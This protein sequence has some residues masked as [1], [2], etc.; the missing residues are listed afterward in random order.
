MKQETT[1]Y[2]FPKQVTSM[3][4]HEGLARYELTE[5]PSSSMGDLCEKYLQE[6]GYALAAD[7][8]SIGCKPRDIER[9]V[10]AGK[11]HVTGW[12]QKETL[13]H[14]YWDLASLCLPELE[15]LAQEAKKF[16]YGRTAEEPIGGN[17]ITVG[18]EMGSQQRA[19]AGLIYAREHGLVKEYGEFG[20]PDTGPFY[21]TVGSFSEKLFTL[22]M[23]RT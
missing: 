5:K 1:G 18:G 14:F 9:A 16:C 7:L 8:L 13:T 3:T 10:N 15:S 20:S 6:R 22:I 4:I 17:F 19:L 2:H 21:I 12:P 11:I 23:G